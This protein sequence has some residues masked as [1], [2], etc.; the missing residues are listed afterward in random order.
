MRK[1]QNRIIGLDLGQ[2]RDP[3]ALAILEVGENIT[4]RRDPV[5]WAWESEPYVNLVYLGPLT[6]EAFPG[7]IIPASRFSKAAVNFMDKYLPLP[8]V[9]NNYVTP[10]PAP[11]NSNQ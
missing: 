7:N 3:S 8:N 6:R 5:T 4:G 11:K 9:G 2:K 1:P 10:L